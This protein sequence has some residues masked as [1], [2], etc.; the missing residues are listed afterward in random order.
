MGNNDEAG[1]DASTS[2]AVNPNP[3]FL[4]V[5]VTS[6]FTRLNGTTAVA[7]EP[8]VKYKFALSRLAMW[9][10]TRPT[11]APR[12][13]SARPPIRIPS[14]IASGS[15]APAPPRPGS[16]ITAPTKSSSWARWPR[17]KREPDFAELLKAAIAAG[18]V[19]KG[20]AHAAQQPG[21]R[22]V[23]LRHDQR[24]ANP[25]NHGQPH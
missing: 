16:T 17:P 7:G 12:P 18:S 5:R 8:L 23:R 22:A 14:S 3:A 1:N 10:T 4:N 2:V 20:G 9:P 6:S 19:A 13:P 21:Q 24:P 25:A 15:S 11:P